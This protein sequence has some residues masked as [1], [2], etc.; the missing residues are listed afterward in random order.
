[1]AETTFP[2]LKKASELAHME[3]LPDDVIEQL[4]AI[5][6]EAGEATPEGRMIGVLIGSVYTRLKNPD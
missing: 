5:C 2:F 1:M 3:P 6:K 4:D